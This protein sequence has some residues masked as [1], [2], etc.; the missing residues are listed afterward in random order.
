MSLPT[1]NDS[2]VIHGG[3]FGLIIAV[4]V[5][6]VS[7]LGHETVYPSDEETV[8][9]AIPILEGFV[10]KHK[11]LHKGACTECDLAGL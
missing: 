4:D 2:A 10:P 6:G 7:A 8:A 5:E 3:K 1:S 11:V 9:L